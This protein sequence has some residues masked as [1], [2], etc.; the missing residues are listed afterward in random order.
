M[1]LWPSPWAPPPS[2]DD[3][4]TSTDYIGPAAHHGNDDDGNGDDGNGGDGNGGDGND[5]HGNDGNGGDEGAGKNYEEEKS[6]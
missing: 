2:P 1:I 4:G 6:S 5:D 3:G